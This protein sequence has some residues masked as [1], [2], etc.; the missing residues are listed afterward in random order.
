[1]HFPQEVGLRDARR[2]IIR[3]FTDRDTDALFA[4]FHGLPEE[5]RRLAWDRIDSRRV[6]ETWAREIDY[7][8]TVPLLAWAGAKVVADATLHYRK[9]GPLRRVGR[10][11]WLIHPDYL[12]AGVGTALITDFIEMARGNGLRHLTCMLVGDLDDD[13]ATTLERMGFQTYRIPDYGTD[14]DGNVIDMM[15]MV[16][17]L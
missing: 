2:V 1:M 3:P 17:R 13:A 8:K 6:V 9:V 14:P 12:G 7:E 15:K 4:F 10:I 16:L 5:R 11:K